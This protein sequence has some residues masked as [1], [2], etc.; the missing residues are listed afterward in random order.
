MTAA[1]ERPQCSNT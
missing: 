1:K